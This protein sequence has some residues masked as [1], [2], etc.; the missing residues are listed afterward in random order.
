METQTVALMIYLCKPLYLWLTEKNIILNGCGWCP[1][2][3]S[4]R[5]TAIRPHIKVSLQHVDMVRCVGQS[6]TFQRQQQRQQQTKTP[7]RAVHHVCSLQGQ[8]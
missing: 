3:V 2:S 4:C 7:H 8:K 1:V 5:W 6:L